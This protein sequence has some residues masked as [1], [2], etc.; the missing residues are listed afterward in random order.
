M[1]GSC[2]SLIKERM[3]GS[4]QHW[5]NDGMEEMAALR[6]ALFNDD[7]DRIWEEQAA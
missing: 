6:T 5:C 3:A 1:E 2:K 4:G 7:W